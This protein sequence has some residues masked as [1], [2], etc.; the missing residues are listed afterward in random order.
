LEP[1]K[2]G[3]KDAKFRENGLSHIARGGHACDIAR[4]NEKAGTKGESGKKRTG[5][6]NRGSA[7]RGAT[8]ARIT[9]K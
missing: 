7:Y 4:G 2:H 8:G 1:S 9:G 6:K 3:T 5:G